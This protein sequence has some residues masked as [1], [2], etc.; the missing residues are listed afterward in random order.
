MGRSKQ[1]SISSSSHSGDRAKIGVVSPT[2]GGSSSDAHARKLHK[3][4]KTSNKQLQ[5]V[6]KNTTTSP[7]VV[8]NEAVV[9]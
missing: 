6:A 1:L 4:R 2:S 3:N 9:G 5:I 8:K 7:F